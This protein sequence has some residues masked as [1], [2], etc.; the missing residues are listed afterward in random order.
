MHKYAHT[1]LRLGLSMESCP[2]SGCRTCVLILLK[3]LDVVTM[4]SCRYGLNMSS[5]DCSGLLWE[6]LLLVVIR[7]KIF[8]LEQR[9]LFTSHTLF[10]IRWNIILTIHRLFNSWNQP[11]TM[12]EPKQ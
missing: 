6:N 10:P 4:V 3:K 7:L 2:H 1:T 5:L 9:K 11:L 8:T 12:Q